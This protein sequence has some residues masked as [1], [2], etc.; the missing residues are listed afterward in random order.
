MYLFSLVF[1]EVI[2]FYRGCWYHRGNIYGFVNSLIQLID[3]VT[4]PFTEVFLSKLY[5]IC[6]NS[7]EAGFFD[8][9]S[10]KCN[11][12]CALCL[13]PQSCSSLV[14]LVGKLSEAHVAA[15]RDN[16]IKAHCVHRPYSWLLPKKVL[17]TEIDIGSNHIA[18]FLGSAHDM[19]FD[20]IF[21]THANFAMYRSCQHAE[22]LHV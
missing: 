10:P 4:V 7:P 2:A 21:T 12:H 14:A 3:I 20:T 5:F 9:H 16:R 15:V 1:S 19:I 22:P 18:E 6:I 11:V 13:I 8:R 17:S